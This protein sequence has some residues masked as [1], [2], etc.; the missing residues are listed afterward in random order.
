MWKRL[1][2]TSPELMATAALMVAVLAGAVIGL[3]LDPTVITSAPAWLKPA[4]FAVSI[5]IY[6]VTLAWIFSLLPEWTRTRR[7]IGW[8]TAVTMVLEMSIIAGQAARGTTSHF[9]VST[10]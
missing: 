5:A 6:T 10:A 8:L 2:H 7:V 9:N 4:K 3:A 1:W